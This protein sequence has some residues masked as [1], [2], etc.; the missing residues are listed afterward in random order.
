MITLS[1]FVNMLLI[2][3]GC[4]YKAEI[5]GIPATPKLNNRPIIAVLSQEIT[6][7]LLPPRIKGASYIAA[8]Y[9]KFVES[10]GARVV[11]VTTSMTIEEV[12]RI[13]NSVNGA[14]FPGGNA[15]LYY[16]QYFTNAKHFYNLALKANMQGDYFPIWGTCL[17]F[18][19]LTCLTAGKFVLS[20][21][22]AVDIALPLTIVNDAEHSKLLK[23]APKHLK[24][25]LS[26]KGITYNSHHYCVTPETFFA[27]KALNDTYRIVSYSNDLNG[28]TFIS[29]IEGELH[30]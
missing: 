28:K 9:I 16:S 11:P 7:G 13:F 1:A 10:A 8:S 21:S 2:S 29:T 12:E 23:D 19:A 15:A 5:H 17:G 27:T 4:F 26:R 3:T 18:E 30:S 24:K 6:P 20:P 14:L 25:K 22:D